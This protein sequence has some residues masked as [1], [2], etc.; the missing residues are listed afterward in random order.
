M[1]S[2][3]FANNICY[4]SYGFYKIFYYKVTSS[5]HKTRSRGTL[6]CQVVNQKV[7]YLET[8]FQGFI[9]KHFLTFMYFDCSCYRRHSYQQ[10][11]NLYYYNSVVLFPRER[12][13][14]IRTILSV[15][16]SLPDI[17][18]ST[19]GS[20][21]GILAVVDPLLSDNWWTMMMRA[22]AGLE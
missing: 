5:T 22:A 2:A 19:L 14:V 6:H 20:S 9:M 11:S 13:K 17:F 7:V 21:Q 16:S 3:T 4:V 1:S 18:G 15:R 10:G 8:M 12:H